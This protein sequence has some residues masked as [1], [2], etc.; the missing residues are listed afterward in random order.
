MFAHIFKTWGLAQVLHP[1]VFLIYLVFRWPEESEYLMA[2][3][4]FIFVFSL[5]ASIPALLI[6]W[7]LLYVISNANLTTGEKLIAW[8]V[9]VT[10][11]ILVNFLLL[12]KGMGEVVYDDM[13]SVLPPSLIAA[14]LSI[15]IRLRS[16]FRFQSNY[17]TN[18]EN[19]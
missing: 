9:S 8:F 2:G 12:A 18:G 7:F 11:A 4:F 3:I 1:F 19:Y 6:A 14:G 13:F 10:A 16:F 15:L 5:F 17:K